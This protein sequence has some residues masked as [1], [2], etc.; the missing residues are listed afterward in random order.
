MDTD[1][2]AARLCATWFL[3][4]ELNGL[5]LVDAIKGANDELSQ[6]LR[7]DE[8]GSKGRSKGRALVV[9]MAEVYSGFVRDWFE[10]D[11]DDNLVSKH[12]H[13]SLVK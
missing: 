8:D 7:Q 13:L 12:D 1:P 9:E 4:P 6:R 11:I 10:R 2:I 3:T 5:E